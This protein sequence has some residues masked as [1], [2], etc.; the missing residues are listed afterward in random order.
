M[1][2]QQ[3]QTDI[4][5]ATAALIALGPLTEANFDQ[6]LAQLV[7]RKNAQ[8][9]LVQSE[10]NQFFTNGFDLISQIQS[11]SSQTDKT[12][13]VSQYL[14]KFAEYIATQTQALQAANS[15]VSAIVD[16][17]PPMPTS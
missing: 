4:A 7:I 9:D 15:T 3:N 17:I 8:Q 5:N 16:A 1:S 14:R 2:I 13:L 6:A 10:I 11:D 12:I